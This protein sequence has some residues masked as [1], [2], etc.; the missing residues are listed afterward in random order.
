M[1]LLNYTSSY[2]SVIL[3]VIIPVWAGLFY[4]AMLDEI[5]DSMDDDA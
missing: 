1:K 2:F 4:F 3:L 5:Y